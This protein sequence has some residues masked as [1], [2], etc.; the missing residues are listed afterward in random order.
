[1][2]RR[3][4]RRAYHHLGAVGAQHISLILADLV[5]ADEHTPVAPTLGHQGQTDSGVSGGGFND[6]AAR[7]ELPA[8]LGGIDHLDRDAVLGT[9]SRVEVLDFRHD[10][11]G[12]LGNHRVQLNQWRVTDQLAD[13]LRYS[14]IYI[15][16]ARA[17]TM[18]STPT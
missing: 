6:G 2:F 15:V 13:M 10:H 3:Y 16:A 9:A 4:R 7:L 8:C 1:M 14:H 17:A 12:T 18:W 5:R 11:P